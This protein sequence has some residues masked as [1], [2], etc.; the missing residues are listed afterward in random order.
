MPPAPVN[1]MSLFWQIVIF[2]TAAVSG[3]V[4]GIRA[5]EAVANRMIDAGMMFF[6][7]AERGEWVGDPDAIRRG[8]AERRRDEAERPVPKD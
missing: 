4:L 1:I 8:I 2:I 6:Y 7:S 3:F 5:A